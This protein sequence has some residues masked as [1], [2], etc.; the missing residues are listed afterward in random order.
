MTPL[1]ALTALAL[2]VA[3]GWPD[4]LFR[5]IGHPVSWLGRLIAALDR[6]WNRGRA[7]MARGAAA[8]LVV[9][10]AAVIP[11]LILQG[12][13][14]PLVAGLLA[15]PLVAARSLHHHLRAVARPLAA[16]DLQGARRAT[17]KIVGRDVS[18]A[19][20]PALARASIE[21]LA[22]NASDG[23]VAPLFWAAVAGLPGIAAYKAINTLDSMIGHRTPRHAEFGRFAARLDDAANWAPARLTA[24]LFT[25]VAGGTAWRTA[26]RDAR[27]HRSPNAGWPEAAMAGALGLRLSGPRIYGG[28][29]AEEPWLNGAGRDPVAADIARALA[30]CRRALWLGAGL[31]TLLSA[32]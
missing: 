14:G 7:G 22:E 6:R 30:I 9:I 20:A 12:L 16:G 21:S 26:R 2:D 28:R 11:A 8:A 29:V 5:R 25:C 10:A 27:A 17:A 15:W 31:L 23:V 32:I 4:A 13:L 19:D 18:R 1:I 3:I 24:L